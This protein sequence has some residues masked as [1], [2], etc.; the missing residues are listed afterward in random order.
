L[1]VEERMRQESKMFKC[2][3]NIKSDRRHSTVP[4]EQQGTIK[5][6]S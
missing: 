1:N 5:K 2:E 4:W 6:T 3:R